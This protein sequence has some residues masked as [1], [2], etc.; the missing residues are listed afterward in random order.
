M[1]AFQFRLDQA[2]RWRATQADIEK[3]KVA[4]AAGRVSTLQTELEKRRN[5]LTAG[6]K[7]L[8]RT[9]VAGPELEGWA[10][11]SK[12]ARR[13]MVQI[14]KHLTEAERALGEQLRALV[15]ANRRVRL[16]E[17]L[18]HAEQARWTAELDREME[19]FSGEAVLVRYNRESRR[20]R[21]S[22]G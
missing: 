10:A 12:R 20:A 6:A 4:A 19:A 7:D 18:K 21:S 2:L 3:A 5:C 15:E 1:K 17:N 9:G 14:E 11:Y 13:D 22:G 8:I 16:I